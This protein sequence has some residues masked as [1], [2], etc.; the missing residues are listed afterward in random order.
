MIRIHSQNWLLHFFGPRLFLKIFLKKSSWFLP[1]CFYCPQEVEIFG[2]LTFC[3][4]FF[5]AKCNYFCNNFLQLIKKP[6]IQL[7]FQQVYKYRFPRTASLFHQV[8][9][10]SFRS[11]V[12]QIPLD[13]TNPFHTFKFSTLLLTHT[14]S[15]GSRTN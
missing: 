3:K 14:L 6:F 13:H 5:N 12:L 11:V 10:R 15:L 7:S 8:S 2:G 9:F 1:L 4:Y